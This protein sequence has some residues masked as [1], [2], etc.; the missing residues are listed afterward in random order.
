M[1]RIFLIALTL[2]FSC[3]N[4]QN[5]LKVDSFF[6]ADIKEFCYY[7]SE[8]SI[9]NVLYKISYALSKPEAKIW[10][11]PDFLKDAKN[12]DTLKL[13]EALL[14]FKG[15]KR[16]CTIPIGMYGI[17][18]MLSSD[19]YSFRDIKKN[20]LYFTLEMEALF[21]I[22]RLIFPNSISHYSAY[23]VLVNTNNLIKMS[24]DKLVNKAYALHIKWLK[25]VK[26]YGFAK[27]QNLGLTPFSKSN[28]RWYE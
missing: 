1:G 8:D 23:P 16:L 7:K 15:D 24:N 19:F 21:I 17:T 9:T 14:Q 27:I 22:Y 26:K 12:V 5:L 20:G 28:I 3:I 4:A 6:F 2:N 10:N 25:K 18:N 11:Y 13:I